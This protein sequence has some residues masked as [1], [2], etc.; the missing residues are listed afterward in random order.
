MAHS[1]RNTSRAVFTSYERE[2]A[3]AAW[4]SNSARLSRESFLPFASCS[5]CLDAA[6]DPVACSAGDVFCRECALSNILAQKKEIKRAEKALLSGEK[7]ARDAK[8][9]EE[10]EAHE[11]AV[12]EFE[13]TQAGFDVQRKSSTA[14]A[15][16]GADG[17]G[18]GGGGSEAPPSKAVALLEDGSASTQDRKRRFELD[19]DEVARIA[20]ED[21]A[22]ARK[23]IDSEKAAKPKLPS[24]W[25][26]TVTPTS[27]E[28][29]VLHEIK[30]AVKT[31]PVCPSSTEDNP[32][33]YSLHSLI[34]VNF[35]DEGEAEEEQSSSAP[36][37]KKQV[38]IC[39]SCRKGLTNSSKAVLA[40]PC[41]HVLCGPCVKQFMTPSGKFDPHAPDSDP[42]AVRCFVCEEDVTER[43]E[44]PQSSSSGD[45]KKK[46][47]KILPGLVELRSEGTGFSAGGKN[48][49]KKVG[50]AFQC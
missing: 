10:L 19:E 9:I 47:D 1:K 12:K 46:K 5:L 45:K 16:G 14:P 29:N 49:V 11:R 28:K 4:G 39:P 35:T 26:P 3:K 32:H 33:F 15:G 8:A 23:T 30:K 34:K 50:V 48:E 40:K 18:G 31:Q 42:N 13:L 24:F 20:A 2:L 44:A 43:K 41:G 21:R 27:N 36:K 22:K 17:G 25:V 38:R 6:V 37:S 7:E